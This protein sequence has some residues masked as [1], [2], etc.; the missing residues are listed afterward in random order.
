[1]EKNTNSV[2]KKAVGIVAEYNPF[3]NGHKYH[4]E[5]SL[6]ITGAQVAIAV[7]S[8]NFTQ[9]G[10]MALL[11]K[12][13]RSEMAVRGGINLV[14]E[15][16]SV[17]ACSN[18][19]YFAK[20][21]VEILENLGV[22]Y[23]SFGSESGNI[24]TLAE[25]S[26]EIDKNSHSIEEI[27]K[28]SVKKGLTYPKARQ[29]ALKRIIS[30]DKL[31]LIRSPNNILALEYLRYVRNAKAV[32]IA[33]KGAEYHD[34]FP[35]GN[36]ASATAIRSSLLAGG[37]IGSYVPESS[38]KIISGAADLIPDDEKLFKLI[39][40]V[41]LSSSEEYISNVFG[42]EEGLGNKIKNNIRYFHNYEELVDGLKSKRYTR[43][44]IQRSLIMALLGVSRDK[45]RSASNY[46]RV[47]AMDEEGSK[48]LKSVKKSGHSNIPII[49]NINKELSLYPEI[50]DTLA[51]DVLAGDLYNLASQ[52]D[53]YLCSD[54]VKKPLIL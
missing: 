7:I 8:G 4:L 18:A 54:Y 31:S 38:L 9:R 50:K 11:D 35:S 40:H 46:I 26:R 39:Q 16:P 41:V 10:E 23:I 34:S 14:V 20:A 44:R 37:N 32:T 29:E 1:M 17:F 24:E 3:H 25:I 5:E 53:L 19:G 52:R 42:A 30:S 33:R 21:G 6:K 47:L 45:V 2:K 51:I 43:T 36:I 48:Y 15:M 12:W 13:Q 22:E 27:I 28:E 49:T